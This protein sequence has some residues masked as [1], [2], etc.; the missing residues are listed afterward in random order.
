MVRALNVLRQ[1]LSPRLPLRVQTDDGKEFF[2]R[3]VQAWFKQHGWFHFSTKGDSKASI[4]E[5]W[6]RT[7]KE[8]MYRYFT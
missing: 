2:N 5:Q 8:H 4:V 3:A 1:R 6:R 7:L